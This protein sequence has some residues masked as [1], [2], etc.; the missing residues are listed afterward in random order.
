MLMALEVGIGLGAYVSG[1]WYA[2]NPAVLLSLYGGC[3]GF[4]LLGFAFL[5]W[6][7]RVHKKGGFAG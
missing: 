6:W 4:G 7:R 5:A 2:A 1:T 3:A